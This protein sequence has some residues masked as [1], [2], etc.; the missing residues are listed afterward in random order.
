M[1]DHWSLLYLD[2]EAL[3]QHRVNDW[4]NVLIQV[5]EEEGE[6]ILDGQLQMLQEVTI[7]ESLH[8]AF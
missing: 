3:L 1:P 5:L 2:G 6:P 4:I 8:L 7:I